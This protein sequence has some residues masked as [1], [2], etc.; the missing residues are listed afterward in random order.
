MAN[1]NPRV[2][3]PEEVPGAMPR[4][5]NLQ[6]VLSALVEGH[7]LTQQQLAHE[8]GLS[9]AT[10]TRIVSRLMERELIESQRPPEANPGVQ[11]EIFSIR[12]RVGAA[13]SIDFG[14]SHIR[15]ILRDLEA[16]S[17]GDGI[18]ER[19]GIDVPNQALESLDAAVQMARQILD[20]SPFSPSDLVGVCIG[21]PAPVDR[22]HGRIAVRGA[23][24]AWKGMK[25]AD[26]LRSRLLWDVPMMLENDA[27]LGALAEL[28]WGAGRGHANMLY[29]KWGA[30]IGG[31]IIVNGR[32]VR[33]GEGLAGEIGHLPVPGVST[34]ACE[35]CQLGGCLESV[36]GGRAL[37]EAETRGGGTFWEVVQRAREEDPRGS[38]RE[39]LRTA[40]EMLGRAI[41]PVVSTLKPEVVVIGGAF[42]RAEGDYNLI[43]NGLREGLQATALPAAL[44]SLRLDIGML[45]GRASALG[46]IALVLRENLRQFLISRL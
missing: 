41:G 44:E 30:G 2:G 38:H 15:V 46:G 33:G 7:H 3:F 5:R 21:I 8:T 23:M 20:E 14:K 11:T 27:D 40:A 18:L 12:R 32:L 42:R 28:E 4:Q 34:P 43:A 24:P 17:G 1:K 9:R 6:D 26:E 36:A 19:T 29:V 45:T 13:L 37:S 16:D 35:I 10:I 22:S 25:P 39:A 31:G